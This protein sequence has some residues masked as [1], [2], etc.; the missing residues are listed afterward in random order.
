MMRGVIQLRDT[1]PTEDTEL[2]NYRAHDFSPNRYCYSPVDP[3]NNV[4][5]SHSFLAASPS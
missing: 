5:T 1:Q 4:E 2:S 3:V